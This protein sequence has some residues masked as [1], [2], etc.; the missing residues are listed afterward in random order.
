V[1]ATPGTET[2]PAGG[3]APTRLQ[4]GWWLAPI[5]GA[6]IGLS[7]CSSGPD[8]LDVARVNKTVSTRAR[9]DFPG[10]A[11]GRTRCPKQ[12]EKRQGASFVC[13]VPVGDQ[14][15][16][17]RIVQR[18]AA[19]HLQ[20]EAQEAVIQKPALESFV[21]VHASISAMVNCGTRPVLVLAPGASVPCSV[22]FSD[23]TMQTVS[24][25]VIDTAGTV[26]IEA[27]AKQ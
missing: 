5:V 19:G 10:V 27:P 8:L 14:T 2:A 11:L 6:L 21:A 18:D 9:V 17:V 4:W 12:V 24:V 26:A 23:G 25:R 1:T 20:L 3:A 15:L 16:R 7:A 22:S 13:T